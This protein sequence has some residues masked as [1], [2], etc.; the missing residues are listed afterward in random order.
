[1]L[2]SNLRWPTGRGRTLQRGHQCGESMYLLSGLLACGPSC[3]H[4]TVSRAPGSAVANSG[5]L[6]RLAPTVRQDWHPWEPRMFASAGMDRAIKV[7]SLDGER[8]GRGCGR[9]VVSPWCAVEPPA[10]VMACDAVPVIPRTSYALLTCLPCASCAHLLPATAAWP[11]V[12]AS[13]AWAASST[14]QR[15]F[16]PAIVE[17]P[18]FST[19]RV[20]WLRMQTPQLP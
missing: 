19:H 16:A 6:P 15:A 5:V 2:P 14:Q 3:V 8:G 4:R 10:A 1:M 12:E 7:W 17:H 13:D 18:L 11:K 20:R 9:S